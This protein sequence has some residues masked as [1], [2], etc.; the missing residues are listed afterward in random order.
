MIPCP[1]PHVED[2]NRAA[3]LP[4]SGESAAESLLTVMRW[5]HLRYPKESTAWSPR[6]SPRPKHLPISGRK[7]ALHHGPHE[8]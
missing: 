6:C 4:P 3:H 2:R 8:L 5:E 1:P 7:N